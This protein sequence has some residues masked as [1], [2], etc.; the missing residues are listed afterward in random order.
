MSKKMWT[1]EDVKFLKNNYL[2]M[3]DKEIAKVLNRT[4][5]AITSKRIKGLHLI[6]PCAT[7]EYKI[8]KTIEE[9]IELADLL[10]RVPTKKEFN[11]FRKEGYDIGNFYINTGK[12]YTEICKEVLNKYIIKIPKGYS[13]CSSCNA[14]KPKEEFTIDSK[15][16]RGVY[17]SCKLCE[18]LK[19]NELPIVDK[20]EEKEIMLVIDNIINEKI[21]YI[22]D[23]VTLLNNKT[24]EEICILLGYKIRIGNKSLNVISKCEYCGKEV[25]KFLSVFLNNKYV[26][27]DHACYYKYKLEL[28]PKGELHHSFTSKKSKCSNCKKEIT[29]A[30]WQEKR[31]NEY[32]DCH[33]FCSQHCYYEYRSKYYVK[34]KSPMHGFQYSDEM[35]ENARIRMIKMLSD[36]TMDKQTV[37]QKEINKILQEENIDFENERGYDY[38]AVDNYLLDYDLIIEVNGD[39]FHSNPNTFPENINK[40]QLKGIFRDKRKH[41]YIKKY[42]NIEILYLWEHDIKNNIELCRKLILEYIKNN[43]ILENYNSFN[44]QLI[45]DELVINKEIILGYKTY[46]KDLLHTMLK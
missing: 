21:K 18:Y 13:K 29:I 36:G 3:K 44:Y 35:R 46:D 11:S 8:N 14:L 38:Y 12:P 16:K 2:T 6:Y 23:L 19:R 20:W 25:T 31:T 7:K 22:N 34:E 15:S 9:L 5:S 39:Y 43:G 27:C 30:P 42:Y 41:T 10:N 4:V 17:S 24:L 28:E 1:E 33:N 40:M 45:N 32:G 26:F 37:P